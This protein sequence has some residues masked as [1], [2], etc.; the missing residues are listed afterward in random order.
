MIGKFREIKLKPILENLMIKNK[1]IL[2][3]YIKE[4]SHA[5][6]KIT[7]AQK[8]KKRVGFQIDAQSPTRK[9]IK[10]VLIRKNRHMLRRVIASWVYWMESNRVKVE[11]Q[12]TRKKLRK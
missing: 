6:D 11:K 10:N 2:K 5:I 3:Y 7:S 12:Q 1:L 9:N 4:W 8:Y